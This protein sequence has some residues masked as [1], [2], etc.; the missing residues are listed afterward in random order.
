MSFQK[1]EIRTLQLRLEA[2]KST[3]CSA[4]DAVNT[5]V[6]LFTSR[7]VGNTDAVKTLQHAVTGC[8]QGH[9]FS[10]SQMV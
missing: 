7:T 3:L 6:N 10:V 2:A 1:S 5:Y 9:Y 8:R 4:L